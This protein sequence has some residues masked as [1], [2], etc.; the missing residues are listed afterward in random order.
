MVSIVG[1]SDSANSWS[2]R[3][4]V[5]DFGIVGTQP[6]NA[7]VSF[8]SSMSGRVT[9]QGANGLL[10]TRRILSQTYLGTNLGTHYFLG[11]PYYTSS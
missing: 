1:S 7:T 4:G 5:D 6:R 10:E 8:W 11:D 3:S 2:C 9:I